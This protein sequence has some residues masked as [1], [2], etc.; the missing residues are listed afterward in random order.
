MLSLDWIKL[1]KIFSNGQCG[2]LD[3]FEKNVTFQ[4]IGMCQ[5]ACMN[6][7]GCN[8]FN[9]VVNK[10]QQGNLCFF[11]ICP[12]PIPS[13]ESYHQGDFAW[14]Y[15]QDFKGITMSTNN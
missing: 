12:K 10:N 15:V 1:E 9:W 13:P 8:A 5:R 14:I 3:I 2:S 4:D 7:N 11:F 6:K